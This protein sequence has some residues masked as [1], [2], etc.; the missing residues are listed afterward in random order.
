MRSSC[1]Q[2]Y[3]PVWRGIEWQQLAEYGEH[4]LPSNLQAACADR[5][6]RRAIDSLHAGDTQ[7]GLVKVCGALQMCGKQAS[8]PLA[9]EA[10]KARDAACE[11]A[12]RRAAG[13]F[14]KKKACTPSS[15]LA[16]PPTSPPE[17]TRRWHLSMASNRP[18]TSAPPRMARS[19]TRHFDWPV[20]LPPVRSTSPTCVAATLVC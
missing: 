1:A 9:E 12:R 19:V 18:H 8:A 7:D 5:T 14:Y 10:R 6:L 15:P 4:H 3:P 20:G 2:G 11:R 13:T 16:R 17:P